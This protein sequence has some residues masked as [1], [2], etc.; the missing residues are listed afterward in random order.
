MSSGHNRS[1]Q[2][3]RELLKRINRSWDIIKG[4][5]RGLN[6]S[7]GSKSQ[8]ISPEESGGVQRTKRLGYDNKDEDDSPNSVNSLKTELF[9]NKNRCEKQVIMMIINKISGYKLKLKGY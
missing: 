9:F 3:I 4:Y 6:K 5:L 7:F 2:K 1:E 8:R